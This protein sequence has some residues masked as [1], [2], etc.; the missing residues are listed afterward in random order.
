[1]GC[2]VVADYGHAPAI[3]ATDGL[4][5]AA[6]YDPNRAQL[7]RFCEH[8]PSVPV[9]DNEAGFF[10]SGLDAVSITS[11][12]PYHLANV[13][14]CATNGLHV[15][16][17]KPLAMNDNDIVTIDQI[18]QNA[19]LILAAGF[20]YRFSPVAQKIREL[21]ETKAIGD[22]RA[23]RLIYNWNLHGKYEHQPATDSWILSPRRIGRMQE[24]GPLVDCGVHQIDLCRFWLQSEPVR[25]TV[26]AAWVDA[27]WDA[28]D[29][30]WL[31]LDH[32]SG[33]HT[34]IEMSFSYCHTTRNVR[35][36]FVY[37]L[38]G[39]GGLIRFDRNNGW[40][41]NLW[42]GQKTESLP[43]SGEKDFGG[44]YRAWRDAL[45]RGAIG[46]MP[47]AQDALRA[48][49][50]ARTATDDAIAAR[51]SQTRTLPTTPAAALTA[52]ASSL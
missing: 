48:T 4:S 52:P 21:V 8:Y 6:A 40:E 25:Q 34:H 5:L 51:P 17:E 22:V 50:I 41:F 2:G 18:M 30:I 29:H 7:A 1:M 10:A 24:G 11:P 16:C 46:D 45:L 20:C 13:R 19:G 42:D 36:E 14:A 27:E 23:L 38:I 9:F 44:M 26:A 28:P 47:T 15:L 43:G 31:H 32:D 3:L 33:A 35:S 37:E 12:A 39:T 49:Q